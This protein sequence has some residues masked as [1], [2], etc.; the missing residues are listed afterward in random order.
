MIDA[1]ITAS[2][3]TE[4]AF[5]SQ[6]PSAPT[7]KGVPLFSMRFENRTGLTVSDGHPVLSV[8]MPAF[9]AGSPVAETWVV[10]VGA[11]PQEA[12]RS[13]AQLPMVT[14]R[15]GDYLAICALIEGAPGTIAAQTERVYSACLQALAAHPALRLLRA[16]NYLPGINETD[17][18]G[19]ERYQAFCLGRARAL[20]TAQSGQAQICAAT[21]IGCHGDGPIA[22]CLLA[23]PQARH[24]ENFRQM[25]AFEYP[26]QYGPRSPSFA[27][28]SLLDQSG[29]KPRLLVSGTAAILGHET[30]FK[31]DLNGQIAVLISNIRY[32]ISRENL[33]RNGIEGDGFA[34]HHMRN[35]KAYIR[36]QADIGAALSQLSAGLGIEASEI[37]PFNV[38]VCR[39][40]L[41]IEIEGF[42]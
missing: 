11:T 24:L 14:H 41:L 9:G 3:R 4:P 10:P 13:S 34:L 2:S 31:G 21:G 38:D 33:A 6:D 32:L 20:D 40:D 7:A 39:S 30:Q 15:V 28:A 26:A 35:V 18:A 37:V 27:R 29:G 12:P 1:R 36:E 19:L 22:I 23:G 8:N 42:F 16:W 17:A 5:L 25:P